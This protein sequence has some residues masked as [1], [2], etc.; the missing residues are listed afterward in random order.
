VVATAVVGEFFIE[1]AR[2]NGYYDHPSEKLAAVFN[3]ILHGEF[4]RYLG[5]A[6]GG[7]DLV[8]RLV[9]PVITEG[10]EKQ[11]YR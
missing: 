7:F 8:I 3:F 2:E 5:I 11:D 9:T 6:I 4:V 1:L 10:T